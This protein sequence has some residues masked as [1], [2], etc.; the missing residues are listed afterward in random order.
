MNDHIRREVRLI[1]YLM[2]RADD[3]GLTHGEK[4][5]IIQACLMILRQVEYELGGE[6]DIVERNKLE[7]DEVGD[8]P[9]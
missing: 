2:S 5:H 9:F 4:H 8:I 7:I 6:V 3:K 1:R